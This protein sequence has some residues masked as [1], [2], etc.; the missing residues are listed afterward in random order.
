MPGNSNETGQMNEVFLMDNYENI[1]NLEGKV[2]IVTG[3]NSGIGYGI[4]YHLAKNA[5][6]V[7][8]ASRNKEKLIEAKSK[9]LNDVPNA[10]L[11]LEIV[12]L[13]SLKSIK[14][15]CHRMRESYQKVDF[16]ANNAGGGGYL[17]KETEDGFEENLMIN[18]LG[19][20]ALTTQLLPLLKDGSR[21]VNFSTI[22]YKQSL[23]SD[24]DVDNLM[25][26]NPKDY[27]QVQE[28]C[29][30]KL[31]SILYAVRLQQEF[32]RRSLSSMAFSCHPGYARTNLTNKDDQT[33]F[34]RIFF[35]FFNPFSAL[36]NYSHS[37]YNGALPAV[38]ALIADNA[39]PYKVYS[40][41][42]KY[43]TTGYPVPREIDHTHYKDEDI[44][45]LWDKTQKILDIK[46]DEYL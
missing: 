24:L 46:V 14:S 42:N 37:L 18:Y 11:E 6:K 19:H 15:F 17:Y 34:V 28:Y 20:F 44:N 1:P 35:K 21:I 33:L 9:M 36:F 8:M 30:S 39:K 31:C 41:S 25:C 10:D 2:A 38:E 27:D 22:G 5:C 29:K 40:P 12:D 45:R 4:T 3:A 43:E 16:L 7:V 32:E 26:M 23:K 13:L